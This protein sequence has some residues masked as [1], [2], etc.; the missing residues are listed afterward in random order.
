M[1]Y[2][3]AYMYYVI[4]YMSVGLTHAACATGIQKQNL[5]SLNYFTHALTIHC[6][7]KLHHI[8]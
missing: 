1:Y 3:I 2:V 8:W 7:D 5:C 6:G 4:A